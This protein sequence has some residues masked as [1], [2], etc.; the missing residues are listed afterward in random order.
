MQ[1]TS[2]VVHF[3]ININPMV[4]NFETNMNKIFSLFFLA[5]LFVNYIWDEA[6]YKTLLA[7]LTSFDTRIKLWNYFF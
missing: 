1:N 2:C 4:F 6:K 7:K 5:K 3:S